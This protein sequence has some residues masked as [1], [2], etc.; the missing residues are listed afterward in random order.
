[1]R[2]APGGYGRSPG[3]GGH[4]AGFSVGKRRHARL[5]PR[6]ARRHA[7][8][9]RRFTQAASG[10]LE[11]HGAAGVPAGRG[12][13]HRGQVH[14]GG[15][16]PEG[17]AVAQSGAGPSCQ[18]RHPLRHGTLRPRD[19]HGGLHPVPDLRPGHRLP[20]GHA[21]DRRGPH[22]HRRPHLP[23]P[24]GAD[25]TGDLRE[26]ACRG[27]GGPVPGGTGPQ[28]HPGG[29]RAGGHHPHL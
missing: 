15:R 11:G 1:M 23:L 24:A 29:G 6:Y 26:E 28:Y 18:L 22:Q 5:R 2:A 8:K 27:D 25:R 12:G 13:L 19:V 9:R 16:S 4:G 10:G 7:V 20:R 14:A 21:G 17:C 3:P